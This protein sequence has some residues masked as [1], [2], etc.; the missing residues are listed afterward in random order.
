MRVGF[1]GAQGTGKTTLAK[2]MLK[3][4]FFDGWAYVPSAARTAVEQGFKVNREADP[5]SQLLTTCARVTSEYKVSQQVVNTVSDRTPLDSLAYTF[6]QYDNV[7]HDFDSTF[8]W[9]TSCDLVEMAMKE[10]DRVFY[11]P[12]YWEPKEDGV[13][14]GDRQYQ[15]DID[16][17]VKRILQR[18]D[19]YCLTMPEG[20]N[21]DRIR[22]IQKYI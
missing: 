15:M 1:S 22:F 13:R 9:D 3:D 19:I 20:T 6:Y 11:F 5:L 21:Q 2:A 16:K 18:L 14:S 12:P 17:L 10:Y 7:W 4:P 8:Y